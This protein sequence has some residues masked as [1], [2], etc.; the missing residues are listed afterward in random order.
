MR[1]PF[2]S[3][4]VRAG[5]AGLALTLGCGGTAGDRPPTSG[6]SVGE[7]SSSSS[8]TASYGTSSSSAAASAP[9][10]G[11]AAADAEPADGGA[12]LGSDAY[13]GMSDG[14]YNAV[15]LLDTVAFDMSYFAP[16]LDTVPTAFGAAWDDVVGDPV[17]DPHTPI[18]AIDFVGLAAGPTVMSIGAVM[19][20]PTSGNYT[21]NSGST[22]VLANT[23]VTWSPLRPQHIVMNPTTAPFAFLVGPPGNVQQ[24]PIAFASGEFDVDT[25]CTRLTGDISLVIPSSAAAV[26]FDNSTIGDLLGPLDNMSPQAAGQ[27]DS[28]LIRIST[29]RG[30]A[31]PISGFG[32]SN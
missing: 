3:G 23:P 18:G 19:V 25:T 28:W 10:D 4:G 7:G 17:P 30:P 29:P 20:D 5:I 8:S 1:K 24:I 2:A 14:P 22:L 16:D 31:P 9:L 12:A 15:C 11:G 6:P 32:G 27:P 13:F 21:F 26:P